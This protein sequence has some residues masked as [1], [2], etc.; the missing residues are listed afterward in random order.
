MVHAGLSMRVAALS[1]L[2]SLASASSW[3]QKIMINA[4]TAD[5]VQQFSENARF[6]FETVGVV[7]EARGNTKGSGT[8]FVL[9]I[10]DITLGASKYEGLLP[11]VVKGSSSGAA[12]EIW[13]INEETGAKMGVTLANFKIDY[14]AQRV[15]A[16]VTPVG[17]V[18]AKEA[19]VYSFQVKRPLV[20]TKLPSGKTG[21]QEVLGNLVLTPSM[22]QVFI[23]ALN[24]PDFMAVVLPSIDFGTLTQTIDLAFRPTTNPA[25]YVPE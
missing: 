16:D 19:Q 5:S 15:L 18:T 12:L 22:Q 13:G 9:P 20:V 7:V 1:L 14:H 17:G 3:A 6:S 10:T 4:L 24:L 8:A 25:P 23:K 11:A 2:L 21:L